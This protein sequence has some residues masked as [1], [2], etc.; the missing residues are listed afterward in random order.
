MREG[1]DNLQSLSLRLLTS[2]ALLCDGDDYH[3]AM[4]NGTLNLILGLRCHASIVHSF[5][6]LIFCST[7]ST[8]GLP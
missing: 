2:A 5:P 8:V 6:Y 3:S 1:S 4:F 7:V